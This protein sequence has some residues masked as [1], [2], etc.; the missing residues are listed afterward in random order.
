MEIP[1]GYCG[2][3][4]NF[5]HIR[6]VRAKVP[7]GRWGSSDEWKRLNLN[8]HIIRI[9]R[10]RY[11]VPK[12]ADPDGAGPFSYSLPREGYA[13]SYIGSNGMVLKINP[14]R[15]LMLGQAERGGLGSNPAPATRKLK[16]RP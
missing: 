2:L 12:R 6:L 3:R 9:A 4:A 5:G 1:P 11:Q 14:R 10:P 7:D 8:L 13:A 15:P 16:T